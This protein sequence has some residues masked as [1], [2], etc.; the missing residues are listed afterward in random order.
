M[1][2]R[3]GDDKYDRE[4]VAGVVGEHLDPESARLY[5]EELAGHGFS[6]ITLPPEAVEAMVA[7]AG[8]FRAVMLDLPD[9]KAVMPDLADFS[10]VRGAAVAAMAGALAASSG[11]GLAEAMAGMVA[12]DQLR[13]AFETI[14]EAVTRPEVPPP[15]WFAQARRNAEARQAFLDEFGAL[16]SE[17]IASLAGSQAANR[18]ATAHRWLM[19]RRVF[20]VGYHGQVLYPG[21][22]F[23]P[24]RG[25][26]KSAVAE[27]LAT[28]PSAM[29]GWALALWW[30]T[31]VDGLDWARPVDRLDDAAGE[32]V[33]AARAEAA[34][35]A[36]AGPA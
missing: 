2:V 27:V 25:R 31:P 24:D 36:Q 18:R 5:L 29:T 8:H 22:Q 16:T 13:P 23:D 12:A 30:A 9:F 26:P 33:D 32:V 3:S 19:D 1:P 11:A 14:V 6:V 20:A 15:G 35:W 34:D 7:A 28:L 21:F 4:V 17:E 10:T